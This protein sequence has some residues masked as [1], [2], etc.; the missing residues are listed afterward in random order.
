MNKWVLKIK[1]VNLTDIK[2]TEKNILKILKIKFVFF[3]IFNIIILIGFWYYIT[4]FCWIYNNTQIH[5]I[6]DSL[7]S[8]GTNLLSPFGIYLI[9][10]IFRIIGLRKNIKCF[11]DISKIIQIFWNLIKNIMKMLI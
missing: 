5:L 2:A 6:K 10:G 7:I 3:N 8:F 4:C 9:P 1:N 11:Y